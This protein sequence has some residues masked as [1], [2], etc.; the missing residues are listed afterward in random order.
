MRFGEKIAIVMII[1][2]V[3]VFIFNVATQD[4]RR[5]NNGE[6]PDCG[7]SWELVKEIPSHHGNGAAEIWRCPHCHKT[8]TLGASKEVLGWIYIILDTALCIG[9]YKIIHKIT[10]NKRRKNMKREFIKGVASTYGAKIIA[11]I[12]GTASIVMALFGIS[13]IDPDAAFVANLATGVICGL[14]AITCGK[15]AIACTKRA[16]A[17]EKKY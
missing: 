1:I 14:T 17:L 6:C 3:V 4:T 9:V 15:I 16:I 7:E 2:L 10:N 8:I 11:T 12:A 13:L 5:W